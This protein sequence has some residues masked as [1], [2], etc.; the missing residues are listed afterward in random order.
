MFENTLFDQTKET[1]EL[2]K[3][4]PFLQNFY[5]AGGTDLALQIGHRKSIDLDFFC[6]DF[7]DN[8]LL[9][10]EFAHL[11]VSVQQDTFGTVDLII[12]QTK[13]SFLKY[14]YDLLKP[15]IDYHQLQLAS[16]ED[17]A[18]MKAIALSTRGGRKDFVDFYFILQRYSVAELMALIAQKY[19]QIN[20]S[21]SLLLRSFTYFADA[22]ADDP[23]VMMETFDW[24]QAKKTITEKVDDYFRQQIQT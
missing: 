7:P 9:I 4:I 12:N 3:N 11:N 16:F 14:D 5:L 18:C 1:W 21:P 13:V 2:I 15:F 23:P 20:Y 8:K 19:R 24:E 10:S 6:R 17:V 22:D